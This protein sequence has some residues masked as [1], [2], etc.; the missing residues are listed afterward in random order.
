VCKAYR[1]I[2][3]KQVFNT[4]QLAAEPVSKA[5]FGVHTRDFI[6]TIPFDHHLFSDMAFLCFINILN[7][8][9]SKYIYVI[10]DI[11]QN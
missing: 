4:P 3:H 9:A 7:I 8:Y 10:V 1:D 11:S 5:C 6:K 2:P